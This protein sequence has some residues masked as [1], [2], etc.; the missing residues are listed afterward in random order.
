MEV[1]VKK[2]YYFLSK[3][4]KIDASTK[5]DVE[6]LAKAYKDAGFDDAVLKICEN[7]KHI[8]KSIGKINKIEEP[9]ELAKGIFN[10]KKG[11]CIFAETAASNHI[12]IIKSGSVG[13]YSYFNGK[14]ITRIIYS[15]N[16]IFG[17]K[18]LFGKK[19]VTTTVIAIEDS[20]I[21]VLDKKNL[22]V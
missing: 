2:Y 10:Y 20:I 19:L 13:V 6:K 14:I 4:A 5:I 1:W 18:D 15:D 22:K 3:Y 11:S 17:Y 12:Y 7:N 8:E 21:K 16:D 9:K